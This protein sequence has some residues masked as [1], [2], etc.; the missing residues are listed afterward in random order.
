MKVNGGKNN[1][2][3]EILSGPFHC[4]I[5]FWFKRH[6]SIFELVTTRNLHFADGGKGQMTCPWS[7]STYGPSP[8][9]GC[10]PSPGVTYYLHRQRFF[11][12]KWHMGQSVSYNAKLRK[13]KLPVTF[14]TN[15]NL[16]ITG[17]S[18]CGQYY[19]IC[20]E[21]SP[22][23][24]PMQKRKQNLYV[25]EATRDKR[26]WFHVHLAEREGSG[27]DLRGHRSMLSLSAWAWA[28]A[29][30]AISVPICT[31]DMKPPSP[32]KDSGRCML[33][34]SKCELLLG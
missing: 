16:E 13:L 31:G 24:V 34:C 27:G 33:A 20:H 7:H 4:D 9:H 14:N 25:W 12:T 15:Y 18:V 19:A 17:Y 3:K 11:S 23:P 28:L 6:Q 30:V 8:S 2:Q 29:P 22:C 5:K 1:L 21:H 10:P 26:G 32:C